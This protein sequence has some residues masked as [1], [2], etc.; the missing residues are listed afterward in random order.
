MST[1]GA[2]ILSW[3]GH[4]RVRGWGKLLATQLY[5][6][7]GT[8]QERHGCACRVE[9]EAGQNFTLQVDT[10]FFALSICVNSMCLCCTP[11]Q[12]QFGKAPLNT[13]ALQHLQQHGAA[14]S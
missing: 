4:A 10:F 11:K 7:S 3:W 2:H 5:A 6:L 14:V 8:R 13:W 1:N 9:L 12:G